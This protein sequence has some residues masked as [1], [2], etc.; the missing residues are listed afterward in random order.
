MD[1]LRLSAVAGVPDL[2][3]IARARHAM[4]D[5]SRVIAD[6]DQAAGLE[7]PD[8]LEQQFLSCASL[9]RIVRTVRE[10]IV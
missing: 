7:Q 10:R 5:M 6:G 1:K 8:E 2:N 9:C 4:R 3:D